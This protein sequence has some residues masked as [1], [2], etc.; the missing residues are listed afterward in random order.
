MNWN[1]RNNLISVN[2]N[3]SSIYGVDI[4]RVTQI[5]KYL[6]IKIRIDKYPN[7]ISPNRIWIS[8]SLDR[9]HILS[10]LIYFGYLSMLICLHSIN[11]ICFEYL[12][13]LICLQLLS[14]WYVSNFYQ[15]DMSPFSINLICFGYLFMWC[16]YVLDIY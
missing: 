3:E 14:A 11:L 1:V 15:L 13:T 8:I 16:E 7:S 10:I 6:L 9:L 12:S 5:A 2:P 4:Y